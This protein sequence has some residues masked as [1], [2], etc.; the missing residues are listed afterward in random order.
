MATKSPRQHHTQWPNVASAAQLPN[1]L[2]ATIQDAALEVGDI[3]Y[4]VGT[5]LY[6]CDVAA[7][8]AASWSQPGGGGGG[9]TVLTDADWGGDHQYSQL[10][11][12]VEETIGYGVLNGSLVGAFTAYF[13]AAFNP[14]YTVPGSTDIRLYDLGPAAGPPAAPVLVATLTDGPPGTSGVKYLEQ[15]LLVGGA[16]GANQIQNTARLYAVAVY[17]SSQVGDSVHVGSVGITIR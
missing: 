16:P 12:P 3:A 7:V 13:R 15:A 17:Q 6:Q 2:G 11:L 10:A 1:V 9:G 4:V 5:G 8:G 14:Q